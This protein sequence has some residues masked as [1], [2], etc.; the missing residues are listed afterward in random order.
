M[1]K[2]RKQPRFKKP[3]EFASEAEVTAETAK[4]LDWAA[5]NYAH[6]MYWHKDFQ[7]LARLDSLEQTEQDRIFNELVVGCIALIMLSLDAPDVGA[8]D[9]MKSHFRKI[10]D[11]VPD[12]H[13][14]CLQ[15]LG[16]KSKHLKDWKKLIR[17]RFDEYARDRHGVRAAA[18]KLESQDKDLDLKG[19]SRIQAMVPLQTVAIGTHT[20]ICRG[21][22]DGRDELFKFILNKLGTF[23]V[24]FRVMLEGRRITRLQRMR[25]AISRALRRIRRS[26]RKP[27]TS[28]FS[29]R[30]SMLDVQIFTSPSV[31]NR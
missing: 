28:M 12:A 16:V 2:D 23:Y 30:C 19:L 14:C 26:T 29:V 24:K 20:H 17:M 10:Q 9:E 11:A 8:R 6:A 27:P 22:T 25:I 4:A 21:E 13:V 31:C 3:S 7:K 15:E 5:S 18:M 1:K